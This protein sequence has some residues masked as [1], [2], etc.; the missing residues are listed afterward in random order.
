[1]TQQEQKE[2]KNPIIQRR[3]SLEKGN[4]IYYYL[5]KMKHECLM[6]NL[7]DKTKLN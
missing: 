5:K 4:N 3:K 7:K 6:S 2:H 1:M